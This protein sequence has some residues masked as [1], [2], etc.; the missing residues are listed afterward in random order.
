ML[1]ESHVGFERGAFGTYFLLDPTEELVAM[2]TR[3]NEARKGRLRDR[4]SPKP[5][6]DHLR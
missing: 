2:F 6:S 3:L 1:A 4:A 5:R